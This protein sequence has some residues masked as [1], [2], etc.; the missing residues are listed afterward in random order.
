M[1][2]TVTV[3]PEDGNFPSVAKALL[4]AAD[5]PGQVRYVSHPRAG[6]EVPEEVFEI[7]R[8]AYDKETGT[9]TPEKQET[10]AEPR[11]RRPGRP[12][13][14]TEPETQAPSEEE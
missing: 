3:Y 7:F 1:D 11:K 4:E 6:F 13:K 2:V 9:D 14:N 8:V 10:E 12:R 5:H